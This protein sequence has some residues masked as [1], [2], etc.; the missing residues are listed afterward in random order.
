ML[1]RLSSVIILLSP[2]S[3]M[4]LLSKQPLLV[5]KGFIVFKNSLFVTKPL[6][7]I[8]EKYCFMGFFRIGTHYAVFS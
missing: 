6:R 7:L 1:N 2:L 8:L 5:R 4:S 3:M